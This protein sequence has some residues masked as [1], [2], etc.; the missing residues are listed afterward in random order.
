MV[1]VKSLPSWMLL[2]E[3]H[4]SIASGDIVTPCIVSR[5]A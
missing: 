4:I 5:V 2:E 1:L 3:C